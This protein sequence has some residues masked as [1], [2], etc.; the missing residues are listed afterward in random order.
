M[1]AP[2][3]TRRRQLYTRAG[4]LGFRPV[5]FHGRTLAGPNAWRAALERATDAELTAL[6]GVLEE[7]ESE[8]RAHTLEPA[9]TPGEPPPWSRGDVLHAAKGAGWPAVTRGDG[10]HV[11]GESQWR[12]VLAAA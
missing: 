9:A 1:S 6:E 2:E 4:H 7:L 8:A 11:E 12:A 5:H 3:A 10:Q